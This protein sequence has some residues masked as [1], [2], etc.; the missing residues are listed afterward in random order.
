MRSCGTATLASSTPATDLAAD[1]SFPLVL[2]FTSCN[3]TSSRLAFF[4]VGGSSLAL[5]AG[6]S[7][8]ED[9]MMDAGGAKCTVRIQCTSTKRYFDERRV[10]YHERVQEVQNVRQVHEMQEEQLR[11]PLQL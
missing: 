10:F 6:S 9:T 7:S 1:I 11:K 4:N 2:D 3:S 5:A 8:E